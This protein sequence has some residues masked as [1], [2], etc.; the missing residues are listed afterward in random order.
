MPTHRHPALGTIVK[1]NYD[2]GFVP[3]EMVKARL[4]VI[5]SPPIQARPRLCTVVPLSTTPPVPRMPYHTE[6]NVPF[7]LPR[8]WE[9]ARRWVKADMTCAVSFDRVDL[10]SIGKDKSGKRIYQMESLPREDIVR[11][12]KAI[13]A[14]LGL[15]RL[16]KHLA[17][18]Q[19]REL[20]AQ[21]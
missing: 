21:K 18:P 2:R 17:V 15:A 9:A 4:A 13:L 16:A 12:Q 20:E 19:T 6:I 1:C 3:P 11:I 14:S 10:L 5:V 7:E 8:K